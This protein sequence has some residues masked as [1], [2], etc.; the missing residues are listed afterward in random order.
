MERHNLISVLDY[1]NT[2]CCYK[3]LQKQKLD[4]SYARI[5]QKLMLLQTE[6]VSE[7]VGDYDV[8]GV[9]ITS[10]KA[11]LS[12]KICWFISRKHFHSCLWLNLLLSFVYTS[13]AAAFILL[14]LIWVDVWVYYTRRFIVD[15]SRN[16]DSGFMR[17]E[18]FVLLG[19]Q[20]FM[21]YKPYEYASILNVCFKYRFILQK[22]QC[23]SMWTLFSEKPLIMIN[24][25]TVHQFVSVISRA[26][27]RY[28]AVKWFLCHCLSSCTMFFAGSVL[29]K[30]GMKF[31][32]VKLKL[33]KG[34]LGEE[35]RS[36]VDES[37]AR[38]VA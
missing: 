35:R 33:I 31:R 36:E 19:K 2:R 25:Q 11:A 21:L 22:M 1:H 27:K 23:I 24:F 16:I 13:I 8:K 7:L 5:R 34:T 32:L 28:S 3:S 6:F 10:L 20:V 17:F 12:H 15:T 4:E 9:V 30:A 26:F 38:M 14:T 37:D 29:L 18:I